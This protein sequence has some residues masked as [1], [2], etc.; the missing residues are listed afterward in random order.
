MPVIWNTI[1]TT[2]EELDKL[3]SDARKSWR[4]QQEETEEPFIRRETGQ[5]NLILMI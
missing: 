2:L 3:S 5:Q 1:F 4:Q